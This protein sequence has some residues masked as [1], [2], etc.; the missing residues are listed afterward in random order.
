LVIIVPEGGAV[1]VTATGRRL[2][3]K[4]STIT[5]LDDDKQIW[6]SSS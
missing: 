5:T 2:G 6:S 4:I 1:A 3:S